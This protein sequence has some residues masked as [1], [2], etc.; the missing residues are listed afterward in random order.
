MGTKSVSVESGSYS[1]ALS[2]NLSYHVTIVYDY[3]VPPP[4]KYAGNTVS[5][6]SAEGQCDVGVFDLHI[7]SNQTEYNISC[8]KM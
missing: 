4:P 3:R 6:W 8:P 5:S 7:L 1:T 2:N